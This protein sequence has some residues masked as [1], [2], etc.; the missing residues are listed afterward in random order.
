MS[1]YFDSPFKGSPFSQQ[2]T[3]PNIVVG[4]HSYY[5]GY[6]HGHSFDDPLIALLLE[7]NWW[8]WSDEQ[9]KSVMPMLTSGDAEGLYR[10][11]LSFKA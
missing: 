8:D 11:W 6:Y 3:N 1:N 10:H 9:L 7:M 5:S 2:V 4:R